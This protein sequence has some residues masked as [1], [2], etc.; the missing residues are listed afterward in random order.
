MHNTDI[1]AISDR[2]IALL[3]ATQSIERLY[4]LSL[5]RSSTNPRLTVYLENRDAIDI[6]LDYYDTCSDEDL[7]ILL[8]EFNVDSGDTKPDVPNAEPPRGPAQLS[9]RDLEGTGGA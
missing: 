8:T 3:S 1:L 9:E 2:I 4:G 7:Y 5:L 6:S